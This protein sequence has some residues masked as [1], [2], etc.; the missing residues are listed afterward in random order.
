MNTRM[1]IPAIAALSCALAM[2]VPVAARP[3]GEPALPTGRREVRIDQ[4]NFAKL[5]PEQQEGVLML[6]ERMEALMVIDRSTLDRSE[7]AELRSE[8]KVLKH[9]MNAYN[10]G[11][12]V[13]YLS[14]A[15]IIIILLL[16]IILL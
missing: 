4:E 13:I 8:W 1:N 6:K 15:G 9:E 14:T 7:R 5:S 12:T 11:G 2:S 10:G 3:G 16:L